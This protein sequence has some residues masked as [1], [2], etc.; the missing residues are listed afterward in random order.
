MVIQTS[1]EELAS[2]MW[3]AFRAH[4][5]TGGGSSARRYDDD[6]RTVVVEGE[7]DFRQLADVILRLL[8][9]H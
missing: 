5:E 4:H 1:E 7:Y 8:A 2:A 9:K 6:N 3:A